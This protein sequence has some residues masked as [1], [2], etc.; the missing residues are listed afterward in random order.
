MENSRLVR[1]GIVI[2]KVYAIIVFL[3]F[4]AAMIFSYHWYFEDEAIT[5]FCIHV[6]VSS[7]KPYHF[8]VSENN[9]CLIDWWPFLNEFL[10]LP[11]SFFSIL[12]SPALILWFFLRQK[13][14]VSN[15]ENAGN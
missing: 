7:G 3:W 14:S 12:I 15:K 10:F 2:A 6:P 11:F 5:D 1:F 8:Q 13:K 4:F 9:A